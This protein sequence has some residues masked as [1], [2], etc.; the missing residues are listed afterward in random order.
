MDTASQI[1]YNGFPRS[2]AAA[3][4]GDLIQHYVHSWSEWEVFVEHNKPDKNLYCNI[5]RMRQ[6]MRT[7][8]HTVPFDFD[9][10][11][12]DSIFEEGTTDG[13]KIARM[14]QD[15]DLAYKILGEV[16]DDAQSLVRGCKEEDIPVITVFSGLGV[17]SYLLFREKV[18]PIEEKVTTSMHFVEKCDLSTYDR[19]IISDI[20]R[21]LRI[22]NSQRVDR[23]GPASSWCIPMTEAEVLNNS[24]MDL[25]ERC[26]S[27]KTIPYHHRY[28]MEN[29]PRMEVY[30]DVDL[31]E[32]DNAGSIEYKGDVE[33]PENLE[34]I[35]ENCIPLPCVRK[36]FLSRNPDH[37]IRFAGVAHLFQAG[38]ELGEVQEIISQ[39]GWIDYDRETTKKQ[40]ESIWKNRY[41]ELPCSKLQSL[42]LCVYSPEFEEFSNDKKDCETYRYTSGEALYPYE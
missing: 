30:D 33:I 6:D 7:V 17:H 4:G 42:G 41:S 13:E 28:K 21:I 27:P 3:E 18:E 22:P 29:R 1:L 10:P 9:S 38:F 35:I 8:N 31:D 12:K 2:V 15:S 34:Y 37:M 25:L 24:L 36:R 39:I 5:A 26:S 19:K 14:R 16:W 11:L 23:N 20:K 32:T 40:T